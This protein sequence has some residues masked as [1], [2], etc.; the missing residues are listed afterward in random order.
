MPLSITTRRLSPHLYHPPPLPADP[1]SGWVEQKLAAEPAWDLPLEPVSGPEDHSPSLPEDLQELLL[2]SGDC[3]GAVPAP[4]D[5]A[6][7]LLEELFSGSARETPGLFDGAP[8]AGEAAKPAVFEPQSQLPA[9]GSPQ[10]GLLGPAAGGFSLSPQPQQ[11]VS[12]QGAVW[13]S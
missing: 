9:A 2:E 10:P 3:P 4:P 7:C 5:P 6:H 8:Q 11:Q 13:E 12:G 1:V